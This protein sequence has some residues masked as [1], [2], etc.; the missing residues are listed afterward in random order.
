MENMEEKL[1]AILG[2]PQMMQ[3]IMSMAQSMGQSQQAPP[4]DPPKQE[5]SPLPELDPAK[6]QQIM[7]LAGQTG[8]DRNQQALL[9]A[10]RPY[11]TDQ[12][13]GKLERAMR[14]AKLAGLASSFLGS[15][16]L[17]F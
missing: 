9:K 16:A 13:I 15:G 5:S 6:L 17:Q 12:R 10:L 4:R 2:N 3:Q 8:I 7:R 14:A 1:G 11:L